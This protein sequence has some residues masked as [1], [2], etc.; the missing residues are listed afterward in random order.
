M[1]MKYV[2]SKINAAGIL[3]IAKSTGK[4]LLNRRGMHQSEGGTWDIFCGKFSKF[5]TNPLD[6]AKREFAEETMVSIP[7][8]ISKLP[9]YTYRDNHV[10]HYT[11]IGI[12]ENEF[13]PDIIPAHE[14]MDAEWFDLSEL[15]EVLHPGF[16]KLLELKG[17]E[18]QDII[19]KVKD[20]PEYEIDSI[21][22]VIEL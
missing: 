5:E 10:T 2:H 8:Q 11:F 6:C 19:D 22:F 17:N 15:P 9:F 13:Q 12:F 16:A 7:Y 20:K 3:A 21:I 14:A 1:S 18:L 4:I